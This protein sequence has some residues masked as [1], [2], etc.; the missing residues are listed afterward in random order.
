MSLSLGSLISNI[1]RLLSISP[2]NPPR[3]LRISF[4]KIPGNLPTSPTT[5]KKTITTLTNNI[6]DLNLHPHSS[7]K[8]K[9]LPIRSHN[10]TSRSLYL[11]LERNILLPDP[12]NRLIS[13]QWRM[14]LVIL[15]CHTI[16]PRW[17]H[18]VSRVLLQVHGF[19]IQ[20]C[21]RHPHLVDRPLGRRF[22]DMP[23]STIPT[24][25]SDVRYLVEPR[26]RYLCE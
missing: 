20:V 16:S 1:Q 19:R 24:N 6:K 25:R 4:A 11:L 23:N 26:L 7:L 18:M 12:W 13:P 10:D 17:I 2:S 3:F 15:P 5:F 9:L 8:I 22:L 21:S 14:A